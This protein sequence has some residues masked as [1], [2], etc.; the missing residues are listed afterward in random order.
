MDFRDKTVLVT[1]A[2]GAIG[3]AIAAGFCQGGARVFITDLQPE[4]VKAA[5]KEIASNG[6]DCAGLAA[7]AADEESQGMAIG[8]FRTM[9][10]S[11]A[12]VGPLLMG[13][14]IDQSSISSGLLVNAGLIVVVTLA[15]WFLAP[16]LKTQEQT[17]GVP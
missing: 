17:A 10:D 13:W 14:I 6:G 8:I 1:G 3:K 7:D 5:A 9:G 12:V 11:G 15:F 16:E 4:A 2:A